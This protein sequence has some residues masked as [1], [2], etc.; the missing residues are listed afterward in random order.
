MYGAS[1][2][3]ARRQSYLVNP[4]TGFALDDTIPRHKESRPVAAHINV[5]KDPFR[6]ILTSTDSIDIFKF[7]QLREQYVGSHDVLKRAEGIGSLFFNLSQHIQE[8]LSSIFHYVD[9]M[10][11]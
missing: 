9:R 6:K 10:R 5:S 7:H 3:N 1:Q 2:P 8:T 4:D 11:A